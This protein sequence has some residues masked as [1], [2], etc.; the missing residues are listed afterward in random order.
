MPET[1][2]IYCIDT[3]VFLHLHLIHKMIPIDSVWIELDKLFASG[4]ILSHE[5]VFDKFFSESSK[6]DFIQKWIEDKK[7][8]FLSITDR[9]FE[10]VNVILKEIPDLID[11]EKEK[12]EA[13]P[14]LIALAIE[15]KEDPSL[16]AEKEIVVVSQEKMTSPKRIPAAC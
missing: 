4:K 5:Y 1:E 11:P 7:K 16:F 12:N 3:S 10:L 13:D 2:K 15:L 9:Q 14:W 8:Y 6:R